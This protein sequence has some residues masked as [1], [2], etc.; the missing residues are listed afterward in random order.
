MSHPS[1]LEPFQ[2]HLSETILVYTRIV[3]SIDDAVY[4]NTLYCAI[5]FHFT[6]FD[7]V[8]VLF[9]FTHFAGKCIIQ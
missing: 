2:S 6:D 5:L 8:K 3:C 7:H 9:L 1:N 4:V